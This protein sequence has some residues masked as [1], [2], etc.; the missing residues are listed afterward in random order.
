MADPSRPPTF[1]GLTNP[2]HVRFG[3]DRNLYVA[4]AGIGGPSPAVATPGCDLV[5]NMFSQDGPYKPGLQPRV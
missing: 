1:T 4:E 3:P 5:G 2:R